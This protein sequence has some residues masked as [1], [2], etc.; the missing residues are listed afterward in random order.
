M[1][2]Q[3]N[4]LQSAR[5]AQPAAVLTEPES[6]PDAGRDVGARIRELRTMRRCTLRLIAERSGLSE[7]F[8]SQVERGQANPSLGSLQRIAEALGVEMIALFDSGWQS[9]PSVM[10]KD[11]RPV[12]RVADGVRTTLV[13]PLPLP[14]VDVVCCD[15][16]VGGSSGG[17]PAPHGDSE[18]LFV[19]LSGSM[20]LH[21]GGDV[22]AMPAGSSIIYRSSVP[23]RVVNVGDG[24]AEAMWIVSPPSRRDQG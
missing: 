12:V 20:V 8:L 14:D 13:T 6:P 16:E 18:E 15:F 9:H 11:D 2:R 23:H 19:V 1:T 22:F 17:E 3:K 21:L 7:G 24:P 5:S 4:R 10:H